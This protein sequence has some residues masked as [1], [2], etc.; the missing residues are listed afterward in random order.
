[1]FAAVL[2][3][4][5]CA[6]SGGPPPIAITTPCAACG[7]EARDLRFA[8]ERRVAGS[9]RV[10]DAIECLIRDASTSGAGDTWLADYDTR[11]LHPA[12]SVWVV[13]GAFASPMGGGFAAFR[14]RAAA[15]S[16]ASETRGRVARLA[17]FMAEPAGSAP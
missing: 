13:R 2:M 8:C 11:A 6:G 17:A 9:W 16:I 4:A 10:Y 3:T 14:G 7:M 15:D 1:V 5:G 12:D